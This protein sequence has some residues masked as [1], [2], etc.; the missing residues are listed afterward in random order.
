MSK[1]LPIF[2]KI[3]RNDFILGISLIF[4]VFLVFDKVS[5][6]GFV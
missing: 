3:F 2:D 4:Q 1:V 6:N 5:N